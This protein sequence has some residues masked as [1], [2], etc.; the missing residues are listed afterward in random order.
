MLWGFVQVANPTKPTQEQWNRIVAMVNDMF[1]NISKEVE[2]NSAEESSDLNKILEELEKNKNKNKR[3]PWRKDPFEPY[4]H[5]GPISPP[6]GDDKDKLIC[7]PTIEC[8]DMIYTDEKMSQKL[9]E[10]PSG[11]RKS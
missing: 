1:E 7:A 2:V 9:G 11:M 8:Y 10:H 5:Y 3:E 4:P 6:K